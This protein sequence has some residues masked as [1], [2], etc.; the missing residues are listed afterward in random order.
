MGDS[1]TSRAPSRASRSGSADVHTGSSGV[2]GAVCYLETFFAPI[3][4]SAEYREWGRA[5]RSADSLRAWD[6][7]PLVC[8]R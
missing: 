4:L 6:G 8:T 5:V 7:G 2:R 3:S 1:W